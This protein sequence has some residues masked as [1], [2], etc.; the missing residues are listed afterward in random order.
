MKNID[1]SSEL[2]YI[3]IDSID[4]DNENDQTSSK[5]SFPNNEDTNSI[6]YTINTPESPKSPN[7]EPNDLNSKNKENNLIKLSKKNKKMKNH[8]ILKI[9]TNLSMNSSF[10]D[11]S[12]LSKN[13]FQDLSAI[14]NRSIVTS[15]S[16][17]SIN[18]LENSIMDEIIILSENCD[19]ENK[20]KILNEI[21]NDLNHFILNMKKNKLIEDNFRIIINIIKGCNFQSEA[22]KYL[23]K[24]AL[25][26]L[27]ENLIKNESFHKEIKSLISVNFKELCKKCEVFTSNFLKIQDLH[28]ELDLAHSS[29]REEAI[30]YLF[31]IKNFEEK[32]SLM[33]ILM[34]MKI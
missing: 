6:N 15:I 29:L 9:K 24:Y 33:N 20:T 12:D 25:F 31:K 8:Q 19:Y 14:E 13:F 18:L 30:N 7:I 10:A 17:N 26:I 27:K 34:M 5:K 11:C 28:G 32:Q 21:V 1:Q 3:I 22:H 2:D 4:T 23:L 16:H